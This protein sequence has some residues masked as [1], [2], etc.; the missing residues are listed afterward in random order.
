MRRPPGK[1]AQGEERL[2]DQGVSSQKSRASLGSPSCT[3][4]SAPQ[5]PGSP[6]P[7]VPV[8][9]SDGSLLLPTTGPP[10][11]GRG[12][13]TPAWT[14]SGHAFLM[15]DLRDQ[16]TEELRLRGG[17]HSARCCCKGSL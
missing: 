4:H 13:S 14:E 8:P 2:L 5:D 6:N 3:L 7:H 17:R 10:P 12:G 16:R 1:E 15:S 11:A 9:T